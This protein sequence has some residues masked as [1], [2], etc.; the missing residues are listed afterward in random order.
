MTKLKD[1]KSLLAQ[2]AFATKVHA[3]VSKSLISV[4]W[5]SPT[6]SPCPSQSSF[7]PE[8]WGKL[9]TALSDCPS[10]TCFLGPCYFRVPDLKLVSEPIRSTSLGKHASLC[11]INKTK[12]A[13]LY[14]PYVGYFLIAEWGQVAQNPTGIKLRFF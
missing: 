14:W 9:S 3:R 11:Y 4:S 2:I 10:G 7:D 13:S 1:A 5:K 8:W 12:M 6:R